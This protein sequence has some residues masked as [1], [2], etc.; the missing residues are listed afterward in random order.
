MPVICYILRAL[1]E[2]YRDTSAIIQVEGGKIELSAMDKDETDEIIW[3]WDSYMTEK[4][5]AS[6]EPL[7]RKS[8]LIEGPEKENNELKETVQF[9]KG[10]NVERPTSEEDE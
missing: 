5:G 2:C 7:E 3:Y 10:R 6:E 8:R 1:S 4:E 9:Q